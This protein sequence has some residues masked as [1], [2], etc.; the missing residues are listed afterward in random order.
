[1][2]KILVPRE[3]VNDESV[4]ITKIHVLNGQVVKKGVVVVEIE[5]SKT[6]IEIESPKDGV[7]KHQLI[8]GEEVNVGEELFYV[9]QHDGAIVD[10]AELKAPLENL[11]DMAYI[12][13]NDARRRASELG[14]DVSKID[15]KWISKA[16]IEIESGQALVTPKSPAITNLNNSEKTR[17][18][19]K[20]KS[21]L[22]SKRKQS[23]IKSLESGGHHSTSSTIGVEIKLP[24]LRL[25]PP[26]YLFR[27]SISDLVVFESSRLFAKYPELNAFCANNK[28]ISIYEEVNFGWSFDGGKNLKVLAVK[29]ANTLDLVDLHKEVER[30]LELYESNASIPIELLTSATVT[31]SDLSRGGSSFMLPLINGS[32]SLILGV[33][34]KGVGHFSIFATFDHR[35]SDGLQVA[36][37]LDELKSRV[38]TYFIDSSSGVA[39]LK[40]YACEKTMKEELRLG[41]RGFIKITLPSGLEDNIC[42]NCFDGV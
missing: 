32:Q 23:E 41:S 28:M 13:S 8:L 17:P 7:I 2:T 19:T 25:V 39:N 5:T 30:L 29:N 11:V 36:T 37:F 38:L 4:V 9:G 15:K 34:S 35:V 24:G 33:V 40:C 12:I 42:R 16:D 6:N 27:E 1:M 22:L 26:P 14:V 3:N 21:E 10:L 18:T 20:F 31:I